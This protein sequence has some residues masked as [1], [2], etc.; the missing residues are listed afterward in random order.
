[1][2]AAV[3]LPLAQRRGLRRRYVAGADAV[4]LDVRRAVFGADVA[5][6]HLQPALGRGIGGDRLAPELAHHRA[7]VDYFAAA[8]LYHAWDYSL[9]A[10]EGADEVDVHDLAEVFSAHLRHRDAFDYSGVVDEY[11]YCAEV[12]FNLS[13]ERA[14]RR[15]VRHVRD[16]SARLDAF[17]AVCLHRRVEVFTAAAVECDA[18][19]RLRESL[20]NREAYAVCAARD[21][22]RP[23]FKRKHVVPHY[24]RSSLCYT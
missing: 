8:L 23:S 3:G 5:R 9:R 14:H 11:V 18:R 19:S 2:A 12:A 4:A 1:M 16:V 24:S 15:F 17:G 7:D 21:Q 6:Q 13:D 22:R 10:D 20:R